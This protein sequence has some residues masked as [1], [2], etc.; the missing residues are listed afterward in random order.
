MILPTPRAV[1]FDWDSTLVDNWG[2]IT[3]A[4]ERTFTIMG[5]VPWTEMEVRAR[6]KKSLRDTFP[7]LFGDRAE[8]ATREFYAGF[9]AVHLETLIILEGA[10]DLLDGLATRG[11]PTAVVSNKSGGYLRRE[12]AHLGWDRYFHRIVGANDAPRDKP[13]PDPVHMALDGTGIAAGADVWFVGDSAVDL[14]C[15]HA[16]GCTAVLI[17]PDNPHPE[18][19]SLHP[20]AMHL[21]GCRE[22]LLQLQD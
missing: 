4:L 21:A 22:L 15:A 14:A 13:A 7:G 19:M 11:I 5:Q 16:A 2:A 3:R 1:I 12:A 6:A 8:E 10:S 9:E 20:P 17:H 18:D